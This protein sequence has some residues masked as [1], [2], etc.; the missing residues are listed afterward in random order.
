M[1]YKE[2]LEE[3]KDIITKIEN[4]EIGI[5]DLEKNLK[6]AKELLEF[7]REKLRTTETLIDEIIE[8]E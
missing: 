8:K 2:A 1:Q 3:L 7:C 4:E 6:R 5:D